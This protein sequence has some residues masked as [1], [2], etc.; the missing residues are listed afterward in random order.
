MEPTRDPEGAEIK[1]LEWTGCIEGRSVL[2]IGS[3]DGRLINRYIERARLVAGV[4]PDEEKLAGVK[5]SLS[6]SGPRRSLILA[7]AQAEELPF[8]DSSFETVLLG[9][10]L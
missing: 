8:S 6:G 1:F 5:S 7:Q 4:D 2:E 10:S 3:G 9:W